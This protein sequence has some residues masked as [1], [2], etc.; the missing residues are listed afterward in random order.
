M[1][2]GR[3]NGAQS[4]LEQKWEAEM[5]LQKQ[6][7]LVRRLHSYFCNASGLWAACNGFFDIK[8]IAI[9]PSTQD[10]LSWVCEL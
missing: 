4:Q 6:E 10:A 1:T 8:H 3:R 2:S 9:S 7:E 5:L